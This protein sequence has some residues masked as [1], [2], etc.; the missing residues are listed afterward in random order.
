MFI[1]VVQTLQNK[2]NEICKKQLAGGKH[3]ENDCFLRT[4][5]FEMSSTRSCMQSYISFEKIVQCRIFKL[6]CTLF[7]KRHTNV[8]P[9]E[10]PFLV[11]N[12]TFLTKHYKK[13]KKFV[14]INVHV[15]NGYPKPTC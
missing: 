9:Q 12:N 5:R 7:L 13:L 4:L 10:P 14:D 11:Q 6:Q 1:F 3:M 8:A 2:C 15:F